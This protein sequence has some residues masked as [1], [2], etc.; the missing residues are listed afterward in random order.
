[1]EFA[2]IAPLLLL[3]V[4]GLIEFGRYVA[5]TTMVVTAAREGGRYG[6]AQADGPGGVPRYADC[7]GVREAAKKLSWFVGLTDSDI[8]VAYDH[9]PGTIEFLTCPVGTT[10]DPAQIASGDRIVITVSKPYSVIVPLVVPDLGDLSATSR[11]TIVKAL[12]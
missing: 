9:G 3:L 10:A 8:T 4:F 2:L 11:R 1:M 12:Q 7:D 5:S 6:V